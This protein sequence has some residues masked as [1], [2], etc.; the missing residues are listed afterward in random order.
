LKVGWKRGIR[1]VLVNVSDRRTLFVNDHG[2]A[3]DPTRFGSLVGNLT[4]RYAGRRVNP[5]LFRDIF[6][7]QWL[8]DHPDDYLTLSK[9]LW[10][11]NIQTTLQIYGAGFDES[12]GARRVEEW[13][14]ARKVALGSR[15]ILESEK[16]GRTRSFKSR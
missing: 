16:A 10:H 1:P 2:G 13:L 15:E 14:E 7:V 3:F 11:H 5:H 6:A 4:L 9:I 12:H 8:Q